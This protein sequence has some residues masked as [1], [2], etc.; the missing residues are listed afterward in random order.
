ML[1]QVAP[2]EIRAALPADPPER[3]EPFDGRAA[4][5]RRDRP[6]GH[7]ALAAPV[8]LRL[9]PGQR[10]RAGDP[11][12]SARVRARRAGHVVGDLAG[13]DRARDARPRLA[14]RAAGP[15]RRVPVQRRRRRRHPAHRLRRRARGPAG[16]A[17]PGERRR[18]RARRRRGRAVR[19]LHLDADALVGREGLPHRRSRLGRA[20]QDRHRPGDAR[21]AARPAARGDRGRRARAASRRP[22]SSPR[23]ARPAPA[24][25]TRC[26]SSARSPRE[27][28]A[29]LHVDA[30]LGRRRRRRA[31]A[32]LAQRRRRT[33]RLLLPPTRTSGC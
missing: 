14:R 22:S 12:R 18:D 23:S 2:G 3:G 11:R 13:G 32:P 8:V 27:H 30:R 19:R 6:A 24:R 33:R 29:W 16:R 31:G 15:A 26:A 5:P 7:H 1:S 17:A 4:R 21:R 20:A 10:Q 9:L 28:G 25:S